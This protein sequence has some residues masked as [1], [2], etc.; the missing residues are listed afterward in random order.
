MIAADAGCRGEVREHGNVAD[1]PV[2]LKAPTV[3]LAATGRN[4]D[5]NRLGHA[6]MLCDPRDPGHPLR[7]GC[8]LPSTIYQNE[9]L[10][11]AVG[12]SKAAVRPP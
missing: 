3:K 8:Y 9:R 10:L 6:L 2:A 1:T 4:G 12:H 11:V 5:R 7:A